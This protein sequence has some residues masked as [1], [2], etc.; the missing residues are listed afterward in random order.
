MPKLTKAMIDRAEAATCDL[1]LWDETLPGF[2][3]R[4]K[5]SGV[6]SFL[7]QY[8]TRERISRRLTIGRYGPLTLEQARK[9]ARRLLGEA[10]LGQDPAR[11][12]HEAGTGPTVADL[13]R[14]YMREHCMGRCKPSTIVQH[15]WLLNK[16]ILP[17]LG[18][19]RVRLLARDDIDRLH[20][21]LAAT[22]YNANR[23]LGLLRT[24][25]NHAEHW[26][27]RD[28]GSNPTQL[29]RKY[30]ERRKQRYLS[31]AELQRLDAALTAG[32][33]QG[34]IS[35]HA[36]AAIRLL[37]L[38]GCRLGEIL[39]LPWSAVDLQNRQLVLARHKTDTKGVKAVPL[40][41]PAIEV[42]NRLP[43]ADGNPYVIVGALPGRPLCELQKPWRRVRSQAGLSD[44]RLHDLRHSFASFCAAAGLSLPVIGG[45]LGHTSQQS[46]ARYAHLSQD[47]LQ[48]AAESA[49]ATIAPLLTAHNALR[50]A[51]RH[52]DP[53]GCARR[54]VALA[55]DR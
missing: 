45:L 18:A 7:V 31:P 2:G 16:F 17:Q 40:S 14:R 21:R 9:E 11:A 5:P 49:G 10:A 41:A 13:G 47:S 23:V 34:T 27:W 29:I 33:A 36:A 35:I 1:L 37:V 44:V 48:R 42:F 26:T 12:R 8:R 3:L 50:L 51:T 39:T 38:T 53:A 22:P 4:A 32:E 46:T 20:Q 25:L 30:V 52:N 55:T 43:R 15:E 6:K 28:P 19:R 24:M 54:A